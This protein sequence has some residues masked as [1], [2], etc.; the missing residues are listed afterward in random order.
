M[1][2]ICI[3]S[4]PPGAGKTTVAGALAVRWGQGVNLHADDFWHYIVAGY[5]PPWERAAHHQ[6]EIVMH[7]VAS[8]AVTFAAGGYGVVV[9][10]VIGPWFLDVF[11]ESARAAG[12]GLHYIVLRPQEAIAIERAGQRRDKTLSDEPVRKIF[13]EFASLGAYESH[14]ID[15][16]DMTAEQTIEAVSKGLKSDRYRVVP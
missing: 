3:L 13:G 8:T 5:V 2:D 1:R 15:S 12:V 10:G 7:A 4:G 6:N 16:T 9:D 11:A 14:A